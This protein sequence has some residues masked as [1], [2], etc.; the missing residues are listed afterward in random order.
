MTKKKLL[1]IIILFLVLPL[2]VF[3]MMQNQEIRKKAAE[4]ETF[5]QV[6]L[7]G[8]GVINNVDLKLYLERFATP[9]P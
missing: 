4:P 8:D 3:A 6:D 5:P 7:N 2:L 9:K 1:L